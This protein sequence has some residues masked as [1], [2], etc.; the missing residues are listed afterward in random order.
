[1]IRAMKFSALRSLRSALSAIHFSP[2]TV[3]CALFTIHYSLFTVGCTTISRTRTFNG[4]NVDDGVTPSMTVEI[5]NSGW[6]LL[7][8]IPIASGDFENPNRHTCR[9]L[10][11]TVKVENNI[12]VLKY[13]M[14][15]DRVREVANL[16][17]HRSDEKYLVFILT[18]RAYHTSAV[19]LKPE[20][21]SITEESKK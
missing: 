1:M 15:R 18:R 21:A 8:F 3:L 16:T 9:W 12:R 11:D 17:S 20:S 10:E 5:E 4:V 2:F 13:V 14:V 19:L 6:Y 7:S